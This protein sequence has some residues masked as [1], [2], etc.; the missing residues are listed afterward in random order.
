MLKALLVILGI[1][2]KRDAAREKKEKGL[3]VLVGERARTHAR[4]DI[5]QDSRA[6]ELLTC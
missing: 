5:S 1:A 4:S 3:V 6:Q 2:G